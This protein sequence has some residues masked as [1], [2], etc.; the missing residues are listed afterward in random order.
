MHG[1]LKGISRHSGQGR[2]FTTHPASLV[3]SS[4]ASHQHRP[5]HR[6]SP[7]PLLTSSPRLLASSLSLFLPRSHMGDQK[8]TPP[9][10]V[11]YVTL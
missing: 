1:Y 7:T 5:A 4:Q 3:K 2:S 9:G 6:T 11:G 8:H 10:R